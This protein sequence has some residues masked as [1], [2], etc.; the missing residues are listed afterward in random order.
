[1]S[2]RARSGLDIAR[3]LLTQHVR[4]IA[5]VTAPASG[6]GGPLDSGTLQSVLDISGELRA[7]ETARF[8]AV[9]KMLVGKGQLEKMPPEK[10][11]ELIEYAINEGAADD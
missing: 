9:L 1:M 11:K 8:T 6:D 4:A 10:L 7:L 3:D 5:L 2:E